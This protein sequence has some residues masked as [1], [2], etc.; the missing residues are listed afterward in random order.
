MIRQLVRKNI[1]N[2]T[3]YSSARDEF[4]G[5]EAVFLDAN[6]NPFGTL[7][8]YPDPY[9]SVLKEKVSLLKNVSAT[10]IFVGN[11]SDEVIDLV[12]R[13]FCEPGEDAVLLCPPT[14]GMYEVAAAINNIRTVE[15]SLTTDFQLDLP[16][17]A[18]TLATEAIKVIFLCS[19]N[20]PTGNSLDHIETILSGFN[21][22]IVVDEAYIDFSERESFIRN[23]NDYPN[24]I[25]TQTFSK[26]WGLAG[27]RV[28]LAFAGEAIIALFNQVKPPYNVS[29]LNQQAAIDALDTIAVVETNLR[30]I[31]NER[32]RVV[33]AFQQLSFIRKIYPSDANFILIQLTDS[34]RIYNQLVEQGIITRNRSSIIANTIRITIGTPEE[35][36]LLIDQL[37]RYASLSDT[38][39]P[40][41]QK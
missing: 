20:N 38:I 21:G 31:L 34:T 12:F 10:S 16:K 13:I 7:N 17:I 39:T 22:I 6:E 26:A 4:K 24:L 9:Q 23:I 32:D 14:Y 19:P 8:R 28:G 41:Q 2:L 11:G 35:N 1:L 29:Q 5:N 18:T 30:L 40:T 33:E 36:N 3:P 27:A 37:N 15:V 25:V